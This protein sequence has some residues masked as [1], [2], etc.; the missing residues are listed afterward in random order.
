MLRFEFYPDPKNKE[1]FY[2]YEAYRDKK[3]FKEHQKNDPYKLWDD[4]VKRKWLAAPPKVLFDCD[5]VWA[6]AG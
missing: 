2:V 6:P 1:A 4:V 3:A 5:A